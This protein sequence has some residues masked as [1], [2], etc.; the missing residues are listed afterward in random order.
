V[1]VA[2]LRNAIPFGSLTTEFHP[3]G[4]RTAT[5]FRTKLLAI[6]LIVAAL[7]AACSSDP[8]AP[9]TTDDATGVPVSGTYVTQVAF[10]D[11]KDVPGETIKAYEGEWTLIL[12]EEASTYFIKEKGF[13]QVSGELSR[14]GDQLVFDDIPAPEGAFNCFIDGERTVTEGAATYSYELSGADLTLTVGD[15][16]C[17]LRA[18]ILAHAWSKS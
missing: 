10:E 4:Q 12:D 14:E 15:E 13:G 17:P 9:R 11:F 3:N 18:A 5:H 2:S 8:K 1:I 6:A 7:G 16:P